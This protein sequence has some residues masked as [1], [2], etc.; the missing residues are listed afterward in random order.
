MGQVENFFPEELVTLK[1]AH[2]DA[3]EAH[4]EAHKAR[5]ALPADASINERIAADVAY[6]RTLAAAVEARVAYDRELEAFI[7]RGTEAA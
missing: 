3:Q 4:Y 6:Q 2:F 1:Q 5:E 7:A